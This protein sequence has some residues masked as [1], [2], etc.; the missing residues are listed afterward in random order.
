MQRR[1]VLKSALAGAAALAA[2]GI[3]RAE[4]QSVLKFIPQADLAF[5]DP[6][7][8][9]ADVTRNHAHMVFD[10]LYGIDEQ[11]AAHP[12]M[13]EGHVVSSD[14]KQWDL[15]LREGLK[16]HDG[17]PVLARDA[18]ASLQRWGKRDSF[19]GVLMAATD[20]LSAPSDKVVRF[21]LNKKFPLLPNAL[22][23]PSNMPCIVPE[24]IAQTS[25]TQAFTEVVGSGPFKFRADERVAGSRV[26]YEKFAGYVPR[27][28]GT[29]SYSAGPKVVHF[30]RVEWTVVPDA[31]TASAAM[32]SD[33][34]DWWEQPIIDLVSSLKK[35]RN[36]AVVVKDIT[37]EIGCMR[38][39]HLYPPFDNPA[40]R[41]VVMSA[42][43]Q[44]EFMDA[45]AGAEPS[46]IKTGVGVF[47][48]GSPM[49][50]DVGLDTMKGAK[51][52]EKLKRDLTAAGYKGERVVLLA[53][54]N[55]PTINAIAQ[56]GGDLLKR[57]GFNVD[58]QS[59]DWG[60]VVQRRASKEPI[61][62]GGWN[63]FFTFLGGTGNVL[64]P[65]HLGIRASGGDAWFGWPK[66]EKLE[67]LRQAWF[68]A[69][70]LE[71]QKKI[72]RDLQ[73][74]FWQDVPYCPLGMYDQPT[75]FRTSLADVR[76]GIPQFYGVRRV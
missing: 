68:D 30:D 65:S 23:V 71:A 66:S 17:T 38:F 44:R 64:P 2:P 32:M 12:Q 25:P 20:E 22:A 26:V 14:G 46:L 29:P 58:Y 67:A 61:D 53:A 54:S 50:S 51:D 57:I 18:V 24:R 73:A 39:N 19:G 63:I 45:V 70:D 36:L 76:G 43:D 3:V 27:T 10:T 8:T 42:I 62:K 40:I 49:A 60:T 37:G 28:S 52:I 55:Y 75:A 16:F 5:V 69:P 48:P 72:C 7:V 47:V 74:Q 21:R 41:R 56:V 11:F 15:T 33:E 31:A 13:V 4:S 9:T 34:Y 6:V 59:L 35:N 1:T